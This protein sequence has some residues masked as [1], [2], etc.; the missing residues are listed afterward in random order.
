MCQHAVIVSRPAHT[1]PTQASSVSLARWGAVAACLAGLSYGAWGYLD[2][3]DASEFVT[4]LVVPVLALTTPTLFLGG[5]ASLYSWNGSEVNHLRRA[6][7][8]VGLVGTV[9]GVFD[10]LDW[11]ERW[12]PLYAALTAVGLGIFV[13]MYIWPTVENGPLRRVALEMALAWTVLGLFDGL[14][15]W[16][17]DWWS[18]LFFALTAAGIEMVFWEASRLLGALLF[19]S[20]ALGWVSL[21]TDPAFSGVLEPTQPVHVAFAAL[22]C[23]SCV[24][25][26]VALFSEA[27]Q[28]AKLLRERR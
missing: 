16:E 27:S 5:L 28:F 20:G 21:L 3:P 4:G 14:D 22:F 17:P 11:W 6:A 2:N 18:L 10:E 26:G 7:L 1:R 24:A 13:G 19:A 25:W 12:I 15:W 8:L 9:L 23:L